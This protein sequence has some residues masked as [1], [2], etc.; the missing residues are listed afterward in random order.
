[1]QPTRSR[2]DDIV[3]EIRRKEIRDY[4]RTLDPLEIESKFMAAA[5]EGDEL[6]LAAVE[7][8]PLPFNFATKDLVEKVRFRR[9]SAQYPVQ[10]TK[11]ADLQTMKESATSALKTVCHETSAGRAPNPL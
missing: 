4:L 10:S 3:G 7:E 2:P 5:E 6:F 1:M 9:L 8:S 11:V